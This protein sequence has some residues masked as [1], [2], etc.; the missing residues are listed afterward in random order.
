M[1]AIQISPERGAE[2]IK[3]KKLTGQYIF[4]EKGLIVA[5]DNTNGTVQVEKFK[6]KSQ[7]DKWF[8]GI[9]CK[10]ADGKWLNMR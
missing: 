5:V 7:A 4:K 2:I 10:N 1:S 6:L 8:L 9:S 3:D